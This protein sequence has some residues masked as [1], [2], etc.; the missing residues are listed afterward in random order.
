MKIKYSL[1]VLTLMISMGCNRQL[2]NKDITP[3][4]SVI[5]RIVGSENINRFVFTFD[6]TSINRYSVRAVDNKIYVSASNQIGLCRGAYD[7]LS[8][9][10]NSIVSWSGNNINI[11]EELPEYTH[12]VQTP[13]KY[14]YYFNVVTHGYTTAYWD[15]SRWEK[16]IDWMA[17]HGIN[18]PLLPGAHEAILLR[19][20]K[21][22]GLSQKDIDEY[23]T[24]PAHFPWNKMGE[25]TGWNGPLPNSFFEK[26][27]Q[28]NHQIL[29]RVQ[30]LDMHPIIPAFA[31]FVPSGIQDLFPDENIRELKWGGFDKQYQAHIL[32]PGSDLFIRIGEM[33]VTE[34][35]KE[36]G[37][38]EFYLADSFNEMDVPLSE[39]STTALNEL[40]SYGESVYHSIHKANPDATWVMQGWTFPYQ[41]KEGKLFWTPERLHALVSKVSDDKLMILDL[42]NE[43]NRLWWKT[44]PSWKR[45]SGFFG[46]QWIYSFIPNMGGKTALNGRLDLYSKMPFEALNYSEKGKLIGFGFAPEGIENNEI[47]Y[48]LL[49]DVG[50]AN[51]EINLND[52]MARYCMNRYG[53]FP[54]KMKIAFE[55]FNTSCFGSFTD[56]PRNAYQFRPDT[57]NRGSVNKSAEFRKGVQMFLACSNDCKESKLYE[58]DAIEFTCQYLGL[59]ADKLLA[60][61]QETGENN[62][63][64]L[65]EAL[66][67]MADIDRLL[68]SH[69]NWKLYNWTN[70][71]R[72]W[73]DT[74]KEKD[75]Y[76]ANARRLITTWGG[77]VNEYAAKTWS[78]LIRDYYIPRWRQ[79]YEAKKKGI[80]FDMLEWEEEWINSS[81]IST[82]EPFENPVEKA[83]ELFTQQN[84]KR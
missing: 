62:Y 65:N 66:N 72:N 6:T 81:E 71:A 12:N 49:S 47:I 74:P 67:I 46:K 28:L 13:Y 10:C 2:S 55:Y 79:Y 44:E 27:L 56:H 40:A 59:Q 29:N 38:Q 33:Y 45:Y 42:A 1:A 69:P 54:E 19:V 43:Y 70:F 60:E 50:W 82:I 20:F 77:W 63:V 7:Y 61:F 26:Q 34:Y 15:W 83:M 80:L 48:E 11:P 14:N 73:G 52:W 76:E 16:E 41:K 3:S 25:I 68:E 57:K 58:I 78:G 18:M 37:K 4:L 39:D 17:V 53:S 8:N 64:L 30:E 36:F 22:L 84:Y 32:E 5:E 23:F 31:G 21:K 24:G 51:E 35:E 9:V 75:Y